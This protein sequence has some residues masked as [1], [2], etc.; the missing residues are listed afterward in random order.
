MRCRFRNVSEGAPGAST[1]VADGRRMTFPSML[2]GLVA[3]ALVALAPAACS[4]KS[5]APPPDVTGT[6]ASPEVEASC[7]ASAKSACDKLASCSP[8]LLAYAFGDAPHCEREVLGA[9]RARYGGEAH[10]AA[11]PACDYAKKACEELDVLVFTTAFDGRVLL[12]QCPVTPGTRPEGERCVGGGDCASGVCSS[13]SVSSGI[14]C[15]TCSVAAGEGARCSAPDACAAGLTCAYDGICRRVVAVGEA[16]DATHA[17]AGDDFS[18][19]CKDGVCVARGREGAPCGQGTVGCDLARGFACGSSN[20]CVAIEL[21]AAGAPCGTN[22]ATDMPFA[23]CRGGAVC[24]NGTCVPR[25]GF[26]DACDEKTLCRSP[27]RCTEG[28]CRPYGEDGCA[29]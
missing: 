29:L 16:C 8:P 5:D 22:V 6:V 7:A 25:A 18:T 4:S 27:L 14:A 23:V 20:T 15:G 17:C 26:G 10:V 1:L 3:V 9:C 28:R 13:G 21:P 24:V 19:K 2:R 12:G 11:P